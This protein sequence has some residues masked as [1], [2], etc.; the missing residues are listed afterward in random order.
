MLVV[1]VINFD[2]YYFL[3]GFL[4]SDL[5]AGIGVKNINCFAKISIWLYFV[6]DNEKTELG[7]SNQDASSSA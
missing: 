3:A 4:R 1:A 2:V 6:A 5:Y 7:S